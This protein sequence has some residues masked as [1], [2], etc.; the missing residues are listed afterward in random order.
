MERL[1]DFLNHGILPFTGRG[2]E[3]DRLLSFWRGTQDAQELRAILLVGEAGI[4]KSRLIDETMPHILGAGGAVIHAKLFAESATSVVPLLAQGLWYSEIARRL[5]RSEPE[6]SV[7]S[8]VAA[9]RR[10]SRLRPTLLLIEDAH[11]LAGDALREMAALLEALSE[12]SISLI[13]TARPLD[14]PVR[15]PLE[16]FL[17]EEIHL[18]GL[19]Q[20][21]VEAIWTRLFDAPGDRE[22]LGH[23]ME[24][25]AGNPLALRSALRGAIRSKA[26]E[27]DPAT[28]TWRS[29]L[30]GE[31]LGS[32]LRRHVDLL[33]EGM[34]AHLTDPERRVASKLAALGE[35][36]SREAALALDQEAAGALPALIFKGI[37]VGSTTAVLP[38]PGTSDAPASPPM[39][40]GHTLLHQYLLATSTP[41]IERLVEV[42]GSGLPLYSV[43]PFGLVAG[44]DTRGIEP[45]ARLVEALRRA[46]D[47]SFHLDYGP[48][49]GLGAIPLAAAR[50]IMEGLAGR[51]PGELELE[52]HLILR[53]RT[54]S[55]LRR[56]LQED[57][58][59]A[60]LD[61][62]LATTATELPAHL[63]HHRLQAL[64]HLHLRKAQLEYAACA[65]I[66]RAVEELTAAHPELRATE[67]YLFYLEEAARSA[68]RIPD[69]ATMRLVE[70]RLEAL[71]ASDA[72]GP[73]E[74]ATARNRV[75]PLFLLFFESPEELERRSAMAREIPIRFD[76]EGASIELN[77]MALWETTGRMIEALEAA[78]RGAER[79]AA[80]GLA[81]N[82][83][84]CML[85]SLSA[86]AALGADLEK[87][88]AEAVALM[89]RGG[90]FSSAGFRRNV[91]IYL[92][93]IGLLRGALDWTRRIVELCHPDEE[94]FWP[95][96]TILLA[97][98]DG[99]LAGALDHLDEDAVELR[100][101]AAFAAIGGD[102]E[103]ARSAAAGILERPILRLDDL[104]ALHAVLSLM[105]A[106]GR[107]ALGP[108]LPKLAR[109]AIVAALEWTAGR[110]LAPL[111]PPLVDRYPKYLPTREEGVW[112]TRARSIAAERAERERP[113]PTGRIRIGML[114]TITAAPP[115]GSPT[116]LRGGRV[117]TMLGLLVAIEMSGEP[118][119]DKEFRRLAAGG[120]LDLE[121]AR[122]TANMAAV[123]LREAIGADAVITGEETHLLNMAAVEV[124]LLEAHA[125]LEEARDA[126]RRRALVKAFPATLRALAIT[127]GEVPFP[128]LYD[129]FFE[130]L[131]E[132]FE[133]RLRTTTIDV[134]R[135]LLRE[136]D[137]ASAGELLK[138]A[139]EGMPDDEEI[140][141]L[142]GEALEAAGLR[143]EAERVR[144][145][146]E[147]A[148][149]ME[150]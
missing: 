15:A 64:R 60:E 79:F 145:R 50:R 25:T 107:D 136:S 111:I 71:L 119:S 95:A 115:G 90:H 20:E 11:L 62:M 146:S 78:N 137:P 131:R 54:L 106:A 59:A 21:S 17:V 48:D 44:A 89:A 66:W 144:M 104:S 105:E 5:L 138:M 76:A 35:V 63:R 27:P 103:E 127:R 28:A 1:A 129:E 67:A 142:L 23:L 114:G 101:L 147:E 40:F 10:I 139:F 32:A 47:V 125:L 65:D 61:G 96:G 126:L 93:E 3:I 121:L 92:S 46:V 73:A 143:F 13:L 68:Q 18:A 84:H 52:L 80:S 113:A 12:E 57:S 51:L 99:D 88:E 29:R 36:F 42:I 33:A 41:P 102:R 55:T 69:L 133:V 49:W 110:S 7:P 4:G 141:E 74:R 122:K 19:E 87:I 72:L 91:G 149:D 112:K 123:R 118:L 77:R 128:G 2:G 135:A 100:A 134:A 94:I 75:A 22:M 109:G 86:R 8:V 124:D 81:R 83:A 70:D 117:R 53:N 39:A 150:E 132:D 120:E 130:A 14:L 85:L 24:A 45:A 30:S 31:A 16:R 43:A 98:A 97:L 56:E 6:E 38:L 37:V 108:E 58:F 82:A 34:A 148:L 26:L 140:A 116:P 9:L